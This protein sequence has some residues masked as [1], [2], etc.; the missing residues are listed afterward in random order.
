MHA[1]GVHIFNEAD[2]DHLILGVPDHF[3]LQLLPAD[4]GL[5]DEDLAHH[6]GRDAA[7]GNSTEFLE[8]VNQAAP[9]SPHGVG[10]TDDHGIAQFRGDLFRLLDGI[11]RF[12]L[13]HLDPEAVH[14][15][16]EGDPVLSPFD[17]IDADTDDLDAVF[18][19]DALLVQLRGEV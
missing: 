18:I 12:A 2:G 7:A 16:L 8:V 5:L 1:H 9:R 19:Q 6:A 15:F 4:H 3:Q 14:R 17:G 13:R 11:G 10:G